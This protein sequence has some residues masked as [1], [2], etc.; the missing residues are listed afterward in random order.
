MYLKLMHMYKMCGLVFGAATAMA[1][2]CSG[3][4][5]VLLNFLR[6][7]SVGIS[8][9]GRVEVRTACKIHFF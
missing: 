5:L 6:C 8:P 7:S 9:T 2:S 3:F 1:M 4:F